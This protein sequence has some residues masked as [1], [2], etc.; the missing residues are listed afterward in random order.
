MGS[1]GIP[2][3]SDRCRIIDLGNWA[4]RRTGFRRP[5][6]QRRRRRRG[7]VIGHRVSVRNADLRPVAMALPGSVG[8]PAYT[9]R[10]PARL[11]NAGLRPAFGRETKYRILNAYVGFSTAPLPRLQGLIGHRRLT[12]AFPMSTR[13]AI[14]LGHVGSA[15]G[16]RGKPPEPVGSLAAL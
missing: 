6:A 3:C 12:G 11:S 8:L 5:P 1:P 13:F 7:R 14:L 9:R 10:A 4:P 2:F 16:S 15:A